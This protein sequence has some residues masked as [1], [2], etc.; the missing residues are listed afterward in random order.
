MYLAVRIASAMPT[1]LGVTLV[2][3][4]LV[5]LAPGDPLTTLTG[6]LAS[7]EVRKG[8]E[9][10]YGFDRPLPEQYLSWLRHIGSGDFGMS[11]SSGRRVGPELLAATWNS[12]KLVLIAAPLAVVGG[13]LLGT[14][15]A[16]RRGS[17]VG[18]AIGL[19]LLTLVSVPSYWAGLVLVV[20]F[21]VILNWLPVMGIGPA[22]SWSGWLSPH[23]LPYLVLPIATLIVGPTGILARSTKSAIERA[24]SQDFVEALRARGLSRAHVRRR[25]ARNALPGLFSIYGLQI[26]YMLGGIILVESIFAWPGLG[27]YLIGAIA[28]RDMPAIQAGVLLIASVFVVLNLTADLLQNGF[29]R[30]AAR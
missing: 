25:I 27:T 23:G 24:G 6:G 10:F 18:R 29:D 19:L 1:L 3:F 16:W 14:Q 17:E 2:A 5:H 26:S 9:A 22:A 21:G 13:W 15:A 12:L 28:A 8:L 7:E 4:L 20:I 11:F 30:R